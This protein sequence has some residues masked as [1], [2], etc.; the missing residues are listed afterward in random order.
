ME[1]VNF[2]QLLP[3]YFS[4]DSEGDLI[5]Q[6]PQSKSPL[7]ISN[8]FPVVKKLKKLVNPIG[9]TVNLVT[10]SLWIKGSVTE[11]EW[12]LPYQMV[13]SYNY[14]LKCD[15]RCYNALDRQS[16]RYIYRVVSYQLRNCKKEN[17]PYIDALGWTAFHNDYAHMLGDKL[18]TKDGIV[19][20][21]E[22]YASERLS[23]FHFDIDEML[24]V[25]EAI[26]DVFCLMSVDKMITPILIMNAFVGVTRSLFV[27]AQVPPQYVVYLTGP[28]QYGKTT[29]ACKT[30][31]LYNRATDKQ[32]ALSNL[33]TT[34]ATLQKKIALFRDASYCVD[35]LFRSNNTSNMKAMEKALM[36][37]IRIVGNDKEREKQCGKETLGFSPNATVVCTAEY[38]L[39]DAFSTLA[40]CVI[41]HM[42]QPV[43]KKRLNAA[44]KNPLALP[45]AVY[46]YIRWC[47]GH[48]QEI[49]NEIVRLHKQYQTEIE[50]INSHYMRLYE[51]CFILRTEMRLFLE[52]C[53][54]VGSVVETEFAE[55][56]KA[57]S[58]ILIDIMERQKQEMNSMQEH[59]NYVD[60][61][62]TLFKEKKL[63][64]AEKDNYVIGEYDGV[65]KDDVIC[66]DGD[67]ITA[68]LRDVLTDNRISTQS[69]CKQFWQ[70]GL[71]LTDHS[72]ANTVKICKKR[73]LK[74]PKHAFCEYIK[75]DSTV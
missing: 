71:L 12:T 2:Q 66:L 63:C 51:N 34:P 74:I 17:I 72:P 65:V 5:C 1:N 38:L 16:R 60:A 41:L 68:L 50:S 40:R 26:E 13:E 56:Q 27:D 53:K 32:Y 48:Y 15:T 45:T 33:L 59:S 37:I 30:N 67:R 35:D 64:L 69:I 20:N 46:Y 24:P 42:D 23:Q 70:A 9:E 55:S 43:N 73:M 14:C 75:A 39:E 4:T 7:K 10:F 44:D 22:Y 19:P 18:I 58:N 11:H 21:T 31:S 8:Y 28:S 6:G 57:F 52:F 25:Q 54:D 47:A 3:P 49:V 36:D 29:L 62:A 61:V